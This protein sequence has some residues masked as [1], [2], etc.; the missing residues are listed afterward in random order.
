MSL[1]ELKFRLI[2]LVPWIVVGAIVLG[3]ASYIYTSFINTGSL[4]VTSSPAGAQIKLSSTDQTYTSPVEISGLRAGKYQAAAS[5]EGY[6]SQVREVVI[7]GGKTTP[8]SVVFLARVSQDNVIGPAW[9][10]AALRYGV[11]LADGTIE[12]WNYENGQIGKLYASTVRGTRL[13]WSSK[14]DAIIIDSFDNPWLFS[15]GGLRQLPIRGSGFSWNA[16]GTKLA[17]FSDRFLAPT[18]PQGLNTYDIASGQIANIFTDREV[19]SRQTQWSPDSTKILYHEASLE[20]G[21][22]I[23]IVDL[24]DRSKNR[25]LPTSQAYGVTW[26]PDSSK[27]AYLLSSDIFSLDLA[28]PSA[29]KIYGAG[30]SEF[31][32]YSWSGSSSLVIASGGADGGRIFS[33]VSGALSETAAGSFL[34]NPSSLVGQG[35][36]IAVSSKDGLFVGKL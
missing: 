10:G 6:V 12:L 1:D 18:H 16:E 21:G 22:D 7:E 34:A 29:K 25:T 23:F 9:V 32:A 3:V 31:I 15:G 13:I 36:N 8:L 24:V 5:R 19:S 17:Y 20:E 4:S 27:I 26:S 35:D 2:R 11:V 33:L 14:G 28:E 30:D